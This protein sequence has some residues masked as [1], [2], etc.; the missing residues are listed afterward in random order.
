MGDTCSISRIGKDFEVPR[1]QERNSY[2]YTDDTPDDKVVMS[3][4]TQSYDENRRS[5][6][7]SMIQNSR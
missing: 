3:I 2:G 7:I 5:K 6:V 1:L 4:F